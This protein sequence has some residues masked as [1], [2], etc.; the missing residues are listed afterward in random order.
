MSNFWKCR[1]ILSGMV[2]E[3]LISKLFARKVSCHF[4]FNAYFIFMFTEMLS[5]SFQAGG[6]EAYECYGL[7]RNM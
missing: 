5:S 7:S 4:Y 1:L 6:K 3:A 2:E